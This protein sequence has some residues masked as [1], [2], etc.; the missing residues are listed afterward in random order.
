MSRTLVP[1]VL[2]NAPKFSIGVWLKVDLGFASGCGALGLC[3]RVLAQC[4]RPLNPDP[5]P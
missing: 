3:P 1:S 2:R 5:K 4:L